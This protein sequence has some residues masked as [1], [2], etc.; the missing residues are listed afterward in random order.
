MVKTGVALLTLFE[1]QEHRYSFTFKNTRK[2]CFLG[3]RL[4]R[5]QENR[6]KKRSSA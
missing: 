4:G 2:A 1:K 5:S 6:R 3:V